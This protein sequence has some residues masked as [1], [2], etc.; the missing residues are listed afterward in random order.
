MI[1]WKWIVYHS[2]QNILYFFPIELI[3]N[4]QSWIP[5]FS[6]FFV[7]VVV[8]LLSSKIPGS[9]TLEFDRFNM[10]M[11]IWISHSAI[12]F[13]F[14]AQ[15]SSSFDDEHDD[16]LHNKQT[17]FFAS[18][19]TDFDLKINLDN[20]WNCSLWNYHRKSFKIFHSTFTFFPIIN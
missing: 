7:V 4:F 9:L 16:H 6:K 15:E 20:K 14:S 8:C 18:K 2:I 19:W 3:Q 10:Q 11:S 1:K 17:F 12:L 5:D 13:Y